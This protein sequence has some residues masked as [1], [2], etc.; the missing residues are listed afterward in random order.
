MQIRYFLCGNSCFNNF[1][2]RLKV[3]SI[4]SS[5]WILIF[6]PFWNSLFNSLCSDNLRIIRTNI[7]LHKQASF[8]VGALYDNATAATASFLSVTCKKQYSINWS[9]Q[10][11][12]IPS[13]NCSFCFHKTSAASM[14]RLACQRLFLER[15]FLF[16]HTF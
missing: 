4:C 8:V 9:I 15:I 5:S 2:I 3:S 10:L 7:D 6:L 13:E 16:H 14:N 1:N 12:P 11:Y